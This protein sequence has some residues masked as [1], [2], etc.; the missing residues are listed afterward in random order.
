MFDFF[1]RNLFINLGDFDL[2]S[3]KIGWKTKSHKKCFLIWENP[4]VQ[5]FEIFKDYL[6]D[7]T[8]DAYKKYSFSYQKLKY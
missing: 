1:I 7:K 3:S 4:E 5:T 6:K 8:K 2:N